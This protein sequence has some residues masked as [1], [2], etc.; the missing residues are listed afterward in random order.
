[1]LSSLTDLGGNSMM[2]SGVLFHCPNKNPF[3][4]ERLT[5]LLDTA[6]LPR[7]PGPESTWSC[8]VPVAAA[9]VPSFSFQGDI[10]CL[11]GPLFLMTSAFCGHCVTSAEVYDLGE[12][13]SRVHLP[14]HSPAPV[15][16][17]KT[18]CGL[19]CAAYSQQR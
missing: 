10:S 3:F 1:M 13:G 12:A 5:E 14:Q 11:E 9:H 2:Y 17:C 16:F 4:S 6:Y 8:F 18:G 19:F 15:S 7:S